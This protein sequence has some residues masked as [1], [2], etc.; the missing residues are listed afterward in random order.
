MCTMLADVRKGDT[1]YRGQS[2]VGNVSR[3]FYRR[4]YDKVTPASVSGLYLPD[5]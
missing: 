4:D 2:I 1:I 3:L 5:I